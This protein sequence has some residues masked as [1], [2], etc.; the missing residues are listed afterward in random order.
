MGQVCRGGRSR[1]RAAIV[2]NWRNRAGGGML[3]GVPGSLERLLAG[4]HHWKEFA[5]DGRCSAPSM[6]MP[7]TR[8]TP[9]WSTPAA[10]GLNLARLVRAGLRSPAS[11][12]ATTAAYAGVR[13]RQWAG[14]RDRNRAGGVTS[15]IP[16]RWRPQSAHPRRFLSGT[17]RRYSPQRSIRHTHHGR[18]AGRRAFLRHR[19]RS[20]GPLLLPAS[21]IRCST[22]STRRACTG[23]RALL[24]QPVD[25]A[26]PSA[27]GAQHVDQEQVA[28]AVVVQA[29]VPAEASGV[30]YRQ[31]VDGQTCRDGDRRHARPGRGAGQRPGW[32]RITTSSIPG[33]ARF[34]TDRL[35]VQ[36]HHNYRRGGGRHRD[37]CRR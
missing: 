21:R 11:F 4:T 9:R 25:G 8:P 17:W 23:D 13:R 10:R 34:W 35:G 16:P 6:L 26:M 12:V 29:M 24:E 28:L 5:D 20:A 33:A 32:S 1:C 36:G 19:R 2:G 31:P 37:G 22:S 7:W 27:T 30:L 18:A 14:C 3:A 15:T